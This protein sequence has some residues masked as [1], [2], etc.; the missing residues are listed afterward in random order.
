MQFLNP[1]DLAEVNKN[2]NDCERIFVTTENT[3]FFSPFSSFL[4]CVWC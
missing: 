3:F 1:E 4:I 2:I